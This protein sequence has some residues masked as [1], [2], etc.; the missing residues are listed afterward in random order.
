MFS[1]YLESKY[2]LCKQ[3]QRRLQTKF[4]YVSILGKQ[5]EGDNI[6]VSTYVTSVNDSMEK[7][8]GFVIKIYNGKCYSEYSFSDINESNID[9]IEQDVLTKIHISDELA[10]NHV[11]GKVIPDEPLVKE[12]SRSVKGTKLSIEEIVNKLE[13][14]TITL[15]HFSDIL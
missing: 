14:G 13:N 11:N 8:C 9:Q 3:L 15:T 4:P 2:D 12:F 10:N 7:Q 5:V 6:R 1:K